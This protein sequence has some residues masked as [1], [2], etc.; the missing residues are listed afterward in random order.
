[1]L[2][3][4]I[5]ERRRINDV[6]YEHEREAR[7]LTR[8]IEGTLELEAVAVH[9]FDKP[10]PFPR[11]PPPRQRRTAREASPIQNLTGNPLLSL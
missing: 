5:R 1:M 6:G 8:T 4:S 9:S 11:L 10:P 2:F 3:I 7:N